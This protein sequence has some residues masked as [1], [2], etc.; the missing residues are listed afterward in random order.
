M[1]KEDRR[2]GSKGADVRMKLGKGKKSVQD[3][4]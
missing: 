3:R 4:G 2:I 1:V